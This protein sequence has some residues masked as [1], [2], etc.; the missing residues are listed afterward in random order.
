[1]SKSYQ[2]YNRK[3]KGYETEKVAGEEAIRRIYHTAL[4]R[5]GLELLLKR[6]IYP[7]ILGK[8]HDFPFSARKIKGFA[9]EHGLDLSECLQEPQ[10]FPNFNAFFARK[11][12]PEARKFAADPRLLVSPGDGKMRAWANIDIERVIQVKG[13][14][15]TLEELLGDRGLARKYQG[16][17]CLA[18]RLGLADYHRFH[19]IDSGRCTASKGLKGCYYSVNPL[20]LQAIPALFCR[21]KR[22]VSILRSANFRDIAYV[23]IGAAFVG[24]I[25][26]I[27]RP[28]AI[29]ARGEEKGYFKLGG[30]TILLFLE[31]GT[32]AVD[33]DILLQTEKGYEVKVLAGEAVGR[34][35][36]KDREANLDEF[37]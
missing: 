17:V 15:Y 18:L 12:K 27:Y 33:E 37:L 32:A 36:R 23:E 3:T 10:D 28:D 30:S 25:V 7:F 26:Q 6:K 13:F 4:G 31:K 2:I 24:S 8:L 20:A 11:L 19:F 14:S 35:A 21:N 1:M 5:L 29:V 34:Q 9:E 22:A 16:G